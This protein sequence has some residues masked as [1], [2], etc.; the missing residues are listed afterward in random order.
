MNKKFD[1]NNKIGLVYISLLLFCSGC[2]QDDRMRYTDGDT[3]IT[4]AVKA[5]ASGINEDTTLWEDRVDEL[6]MLAFNPQDG[7]VVFNQKLYFPDGFNSLSKAV[8]IKP[9]IYN[10]YFIAN[11]T[12]YTGDFVNALIDIRNESEFETDPRFTNIPY[13]PSFLPNGTTVDGRFVMSAVY[14]NLTVAGGGSENNPALLVVPNG[15]VELIR[16]LAKI[17]VIFR[18]RISGS[19]VPDNTIISVLIEN[20]ASYISVPPVRY[21]LYISTNIFRSRFTYQ[22]GLFKR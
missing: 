4:I 6:R 3:M 12:V 22:S 17:E 16:S 1:I 15:R 13:N 14:D 8:R 10:F 20:V 5:A 19:E 21:L 9:G 11:E 2:N 7:S 18:K